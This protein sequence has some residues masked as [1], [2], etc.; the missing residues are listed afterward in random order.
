MTKLLRPPFR[1]PNLAGDQFRKL[2]LE[3]GGLW[4]KGTHAVWRV[5]L[6]AQ[7]QADFIRGRLDDELTGELKRY[8]RELDLPEL[9]DLQAPPYA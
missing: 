1:L 8:R 9:P 2:Q 3:I 6:M 7:H 5:A 4:G